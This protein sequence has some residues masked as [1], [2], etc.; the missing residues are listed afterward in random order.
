MI[1]PFADVTGDGF[2]V[3]SRSTNRKDTEDDIVK[4]I[5]NSLRPTEAGVVEQIL[6]GLQ[7]H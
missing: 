6:E 7:F 1:S 5:T 2:A 3:A 4:A